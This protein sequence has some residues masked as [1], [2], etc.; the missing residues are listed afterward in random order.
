MSAFKDALENE[1]DMKRF[2]Q[3]IRDNYIK[4]SFISMSSGSSF[5]PD[6]QRD[7]RI[8]SSHSSSLDDCGPLESKSKFF[9]NTESKEIEESD[10]NNIDFIMNQSPKPSEYLP[11]NIYRPAY[12]YKKYKYADLFRI[13]IINVF[14]FTFLF[15]TVQI[16]SILLNLPLYLSYFLRIT[17]HNIILLFVSL[18]FNSEEAYRS[19]N[20]TMETN[21]IHTILFNYT[22][23]DTIVYMSIQVCVTFFTNVL[24]FSILYRP[25]QQISIGILME[26]MVYYSNHVSFISIDI[27]IYASI[28]YYTIELI[29]LITIQTQ[30]SDRLTSIEYKK[31]IYMKTGLFLLFNMT[32]TG[33][34]SFITSVSYTF[35]TA[36]AL[37]LMKSDIAPLAYQYYMSTILFGITIIIAPCTAWIGYYHLRYF[38]NKYIE[39]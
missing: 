38:Y 16:V 10:S 13:E 12:L 9:I 4:R 34:T 7:M 11:P 39:I 25:I 21:M 26:N 1:Q 22:I 24:V 36:C 18:L 32:F 29:I 6:H 33:I 31:I 20:I 15:S 27:P 8:S 2:E 14:L 5:D 19:I 23:L 35:G 3:E 17:S 37:V 30:I 28:L